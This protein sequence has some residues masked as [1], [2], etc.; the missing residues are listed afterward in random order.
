LIL[1]LGLVASVDATLNDTPV[2]TLVDDAYRGRVLAIY[3]MLWGL[4][5]IFRRGDPHRLTQRPVTGVVG[6]R[7]LR[8]CAAS[9]VR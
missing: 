6:G 8:R 3:S 9:S 2:Q 1:L 7:A 4:T 5:P